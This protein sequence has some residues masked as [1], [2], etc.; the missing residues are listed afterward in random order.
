MGIGAV[1]LFRLQK[2]PGRH[3][4]KSR[5]ELLDFNGHKLWEA[6]KKK[7]DSKSMV[8][9]DNCASSA[10]IQIYFNLFVDGGQWSF[11]RKAKIPWKEQQIPQQKLLRYFF[12]KTS[13]THTKIPVLMLGLVDLFRC[14]APPKKSPSSAE[15]RSVDDIP[16][17]WFRPRL[18]VVHSRWWTGCGEVTLGWENAGVMDGKSF[19]SCTFF[20]FGLVRGDNWNEIWVVSDS[21][22]LSWS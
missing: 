7:T 4:E 1:T 3:H 22:W 17:K 15:T 13:S 5:I 11:S 21:W 16:W 8:S 14:P 19:F 6:E 9:D 2:R 20:S 10:R 12:S 18:R